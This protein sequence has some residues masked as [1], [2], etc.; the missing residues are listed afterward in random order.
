MVPAGSGDWQLKSS[1]GVGPEGVG[2]W[3]QPGLYRY[4]LS[5]SDI[6]NWVVSDPLPRIDDAVG[7]PPP[8][9]ST[10]PAPGTRAARAAPTAKRDASTRLLLIGFLPT[11]SDFGPDC[12]RPRLGYSSLL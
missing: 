12:I 10:W 1:Q 2:I 7:P 8:L 4:S 11:S 3:A 9:A 5:T 6:M